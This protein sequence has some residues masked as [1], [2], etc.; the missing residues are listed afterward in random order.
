M[1]QYTLRSRALR[2]NLTEAEKYLWYLLRRKQINSLKFRRQA[3]IGKY[4][5]DFVCFEKNLVVE[6]DGSQ[7]YQSEHDIIRDAWLQSQGFKVIRFW[8]N[9]VLENRDGVLEKIIESLK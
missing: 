8:N 7:H 3:V 2:N 5:V 1:R 9:E 4:I 6:V